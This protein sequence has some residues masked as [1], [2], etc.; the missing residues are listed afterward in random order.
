MSQKKG[1]H[2]D[3]EFKLSV[4]LEVLREELTLSQIASK[5]GVSPRVLSNW[6]KEFLE[7]AFMAF[8]KNKLAKEQKKEIQDLEAEK[9]DLYK[10]IG[11]LSAE[12]SWAEKKIKSFKLD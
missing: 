1:K 9:E 12:L 6:K 3:A 2:Y 4:T 8:S 10:Q 11:K 7:N 5:H